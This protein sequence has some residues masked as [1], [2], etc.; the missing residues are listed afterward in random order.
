MLL[1]TSLR[2]FLAHKGRMALSLIAVVL[3]VAFVSGTLVFSNTATSTFDKLFASTASDVS[4]RPHSDDTAD[5]QVGG[6]VGT[7]PVQTVQKVSG[8]PGVKSAV[9]EVLVS[10]AVLVDPATNKTV[11]P[12]SGAP[13]LTGSWVETPRKSLEITSG[14]APQGSGQVLLD[15][16]TAKKAGLRLDSPLRLI[17]AT[18][19]YD[20]KISGIA[21]FRTTNPGAALAFLDTPTAQRLLLDS[22]AYTSVEVFGD[23]S[24]SNDELRTEAATAVGTGF[25]LKT[26]A[27]QKAENA[28]SVGS[29][30]DFMK[31]AMLGFAG[32]S[33]LVGGF[34]I[35]NT[36]SMLVA[37]RTREIGLLRAIGG[38]R[39]QV[40][41]SVLVEAL[42]LAVLGSTLGLFGGIGLAVLLIQLMS[43]VGMNLTSAALE[44]GASVPIASYTVG[45]VIT[46][47]AAF[48]PA[49]RAG[50][51]SPMS[52][53]RD[54]G[55]PTEARANRIRAAAGLVL[56]AGGAGLLVAA[57]QAG[58]AATG[59][60]FLGLGVVL[61]LIGFVVIGPLLAT[62]LIRVL[63]AV[64]PALF[65]PSG[66]LAQRNAMRNPRRTG[67][68]AAALM[69]GLALVIGASVFTSSMVSSTNAQIDKSVGADYVV[70]GN[71]NGLT[72]AMVSAAKSAKGLAHLTEQKQLAATLTLPDGSTSKTQLAAV[73][74]T[75]VDDFRLPVKAGSATTI[76]GGGISVDEDFATRHHLS[77]GDRLTADYGQGHTQ[78]LVLGLITAKGNSFSD[79]NLFIGLDTV[80]K[81]VP[82][83]ELPQDA[84]LFGKAEAGADK[85]RTL[86]ALQ[87][88]LKAYPQLTVQDQAGYKKIVQDQINT[89]LYMVYGLLLLA[90]V[91]AVLG[92]VNTLALSVVER[93]REIGLL[94]AIGLSRRQLRRMIRLESV[95][96]AVFGAL[97]GTGLGLAW[98]ITAQRVLVDKG[99]STL[100]IPTEKIVVILLASAVIGLL[101]ALLPAFRAGRMNVLAAIATD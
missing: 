23:G 67:A 74:P 72:P 44:I 92:V 66:R 46:L 40:N 42:I 95:V 36:F 86:D 81:A 63:G 49:R 32:I 68:T 25:D 91:V 96:I 29:F 87:T 78:S 9:G 26:A 13:T 8:L 85:A 50:K 89:L 100:A 12:T 60:A 6:K 38:S 62:G 94:R 41:G 51:I 52:A 101:A 71:Q 24:R 16:D 76:T 2:S 80:A 39:G 19:S 14:R 37:Q 69:I 57:A 18:G 56:T 90:I 30:L 31:Y 84:A 58:K 82:A 22:T 3:S 61:T 11:G 4:V 47:V 34:L 55:T 17:T 28:K 43:A 5:R 27:E 65:G 98:G 1:K 53:L 21:T 64:L 70:Q 45:I 7:V 79:G 93:T 77:V 83:A 35:I 10:S 20:L 88:A 48:I 59:G 75:F 54:H 15:S 73:S 99:L 97:L 33:L